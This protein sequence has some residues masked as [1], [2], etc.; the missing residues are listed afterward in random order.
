M[1]SKTKN[2]RTLFCV[3]FVISILLNICPLAVYAI[4]AV[5]E[6]TLIY[7][8]VTL[9]MTVFIVLLM[10]IV[11]VVNKVAMKSRLWIILIGVYIC[12]DYIMTP[13]I[14]IAVCQILDELVA[15]PLKQ[16]YKNK[17]TIS[18]EIDGRL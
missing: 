17:F 16:R 8:K 11:S 2:Y 4:K 18:K 9:V 7:E 13:L 10:T 3:F 14:I 1:S 6:S 12:L 5:V 15:F